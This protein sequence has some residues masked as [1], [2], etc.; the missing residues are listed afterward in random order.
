MTK[1]D[2]REVYSETLPPILVLR[3]LNIKPLLIFRITNISLQPR[4]FIAR[5]EE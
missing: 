3:I 1:T 5:A 2:L 4:M